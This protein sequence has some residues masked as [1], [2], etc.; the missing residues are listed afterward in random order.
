MS[1]DNKRPPLRP[2]AVPGG[3]S[4]RR[5][6]REYALQGLYQ[7][8]VG[9]ADEAAIEAHLP[10]LDDYLTLKEA[11]RAFCVDLI[12]GTLGDLSTL[13]AAIQPHLDRP[14]DE[15]SPVE[16][17]ILLLGAHELAHH[18]QTP[19]RVI[20]N[21]MIELAKTF[22]GTDGHKYVNGVLDKLAAHFRAVELA[23]RRGDA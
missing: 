2:G 15:L 18:P 11:D 13:V 20:I 5:R 16:A 23:A 7:W 19:Y 9:G 3:K 6:A 4:A 12:R 17:C 10:E 21:E 22:G 8:R 14:Y 1:Q